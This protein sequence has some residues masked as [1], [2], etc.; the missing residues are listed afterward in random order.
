MPALFMVEQAELLDTR[1]DARLILLTVGIACVAGA[2]F[3]VA[4]A[5]LGTASSAVTAL[6]ADPGGVSVQ[7]GARLR[8]LLAGG[9]IALSTLLLLATGILVASLTHA[10]QGDLEFTA[11]SVAFVSL[12][13]PGQ[14]GDPVRGIGCRNTLLARVSTV[15]GVE[16]VGWASTLPLVSG[17][18]HVFRIEGKTADVRDTVE[19]DTNVVSPDYFRTLSLPCIEGRVFDE[20]D[21]ALAPPVLM[22]DELLA[23]RY[24][25]PTAT[26]H[27]LIDVQGT[28]LEIV[29]VVRSG[30]YRTLQQA[31]QPTVY[32]PAAQEYLWRGHL[33]ARTVRDPATLL[34][35]IDQAVRGGN[36][37]NVLESSTLETHLADSLALDRLTTTLVGLCGVIALAMATIGVYGVMMDA[38]QRRTREIGLRVAL[39][40]RRAQ[41]ALLVLMEATYLA[42]AGLLIGAAAAVAISRLARSRLPGVPSVDVVML[43]VTSSA[44]AVVVMLAAIVPLRRALRVNPTIALR[45]E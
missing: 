27:Y 26:R 8:A 22:V 32:Y 37:A 18:R 21:H 36:C 15:N 2:L 45:A 11:K 40:A 39:G 31:P 16:T 30:R 9:Q 13:L 42:A 44:L 1:V 28:R 24:F 6:R 34:G 7:H 33:V 3:G 20:R 29:G 14:F 10:L 41:V 5:L 19:F 43:T 35:A 4:P 25:G 38:V 23:R 12:E 17:N